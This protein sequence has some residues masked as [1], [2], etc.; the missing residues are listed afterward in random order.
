MLCFPKGWT[1]GDRL[2][3]R[4]CETT[5]LC[6]ANRVTWTNFNAVQCLWISCVTNLSEQAYESGKQRIT[7]PSLCTPPPF[8]PQWVC[9]GDKQCCPVESEH[10]S[11]ARSEKGAWKE[12]GWVVFRFRVAFPSWAVCGK[13]LQGPQTRHSFTPRHYDRAGEQRQSRRWGQG[14]GGHTEELFKL[15]RKKEEGV[16]KCGLN[17]NMDQTQVIFQAQQ[18]PQLNKRMGNLNNQIYNCRLCSKMLSSSIS[19]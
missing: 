14:G 5:C 9:E 10:Y 15:K 12:E 8:V 3:K 1:S 7:A 11:G 19:E 16:V 6:N 2:P 13:T 18:C 4:P 17:N